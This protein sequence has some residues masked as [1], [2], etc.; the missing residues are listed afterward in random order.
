VVAAL[1]TIDHQDSLLMV[2]MYTDEQ[3]K[4]LAMQ[5]KRDK[6]ADLDQSTDSGGDRPNTVPGGQMVSRFGAAG[7]VQSSFFAY[8]EKSLSQGQKEFK[9]VWG[10]RKLADN[11]RY[12][13]TGGNITIDDSASQGRSVSLGITQTE[14]DE[15]LQEVPG[16]PEEKE[17]IKQLIDQTMLKLGFAFRS[18]LNELEKSNETL[19]QLIERKPAREIHAE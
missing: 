17:N 11:W 1:E 9:K 18:D 12:S 2:S 8:N 13:S 10:E 7:A 6:Q 5:I 15:I 4:E 16:T 19:I 3:K 14:I